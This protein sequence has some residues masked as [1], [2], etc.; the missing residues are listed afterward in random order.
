MNINVLRKLFLVATLI[1]SNI[2]YADGTPWGKLEVERGPVIVIMTYQMNYAEPGNPNNQYSKP[3][4][5]FPQI[6]ANPIYIRLEV[7]QTPDHQCSVTPK[8]ISLIIENPAGDRVKAPELLKIDQAPMT[9]TGRCAFQAFFL[10]AMV[11]ARELEPGKPL[12]QLRQKLIINYEGGKS[13][14]FKINMYSDNE[15]R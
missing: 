5:H 3:S 8:S 11:L 9:M 15:F 12:E 10:P 1:Y 6:I 14:V 4:I 7:L 2:A 13:E